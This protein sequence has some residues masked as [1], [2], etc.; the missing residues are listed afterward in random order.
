MRLYVLRHGD[1]VESPYYHDSQRPLSDRG[2]EQIKAV[3]RFLKR[4]RASLDLILTSPLHRAR[5]TAEI[6]QQ[7]MGIHDLMTTESLISGSNLRDLIIVVNDHPV[8]CLLLVG[9]EP[10][11]SSAI[12]LLTAGDEQFRLEMRKGS[13]AC[14]ET[15]HPVKKGQAVLSWLLGVEQM[16]LLR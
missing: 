6:V 8:E 11:L 16:E 2:R 3:V 13:L 14:L 4:S 10:Q 15:K 7:N 12:S 5:E 1:A 9:H